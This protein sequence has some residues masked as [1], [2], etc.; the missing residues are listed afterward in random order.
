MRNP[1]NVNANG[2]TKMS[3][4]R[5]EV[6]SNSSS[7]MPTAYRTEEISQLK[8]HGTQRGSTTSEDEV[9]RRQNLSFTHSWTK[10]IANDTQPERYD[11]KHEKGKRVPACVKNCDDK[12]EN[13]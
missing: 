6:D 7:T 8:C 4:T 9:S 3:S 13:G 10:V 12:E 11:E 5:A 1:L 2:T